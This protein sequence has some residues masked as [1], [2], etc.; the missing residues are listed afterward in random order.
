MVLFS[1]VKTARPRPAEKATPV[2][3]CTCDGKQMRISLTEKGGENGL[4]HLFSLIC[5]S[6]PSSVITLLKTCGYLFKNVIQEA[7]FK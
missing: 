5:N 2:M 4:H 3:T 6:C 7:P 1:T